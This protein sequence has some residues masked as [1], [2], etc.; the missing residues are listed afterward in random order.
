MKRLFHFSRSDPGGVQD[1]AN[2]CHLEI[3]SLTWASDILDHK[4]FGWVITEMAQE[5]VRNRWEHAPDRRENDQI[6]FIDVS[7]RRKCIELWRSI[8][9]SKQEWSPEA[10]FCTARTL[11][12]RGML[13]QEDLICEE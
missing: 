3:H 6:Y 12:L 4:F 11:L 1:E 10:I 5:E 9:T 2:E 7:T 13:K 8:L